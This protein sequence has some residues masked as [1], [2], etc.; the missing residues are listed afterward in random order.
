M[1]AIVIV[2][3]GHAG[4]ELANA[5]RQ[6]GFAGR[7]ILVSDDPA[8]P[9]HRPPLSKDF[10]KGDGLSPLLLKAESFYPQNE[11]ELQLG[12][13]AVAIDRSAQRV[14]LDDG[15]ILAYD[16]LV[17]A[18]GARNRPLPIVGADHDEV[19]TL[20]DLA[21][22]RRILSRLPGLRH[23]AIVGGGFI[24]L[25][26]AAHLREKHIGVDLVE[27]TDRL[28]SRAVSSVMSD[29]FRRFH[30]ELGVTLH[31]QRQAQAI[32]HDSGRATL[33][34]TD[35][36][37]IAADAVLLAAGIVPNTELAADAGLAVGNGI[38]VDAHLLTS[39]PAIS[40]LGDCA[41]FPSRFAGG[42]TRLESVQNA[43]D[44]ARCIAKRLTGQP[45]AY[46]AV[47]WFWSNQG[48]ARLQIA[49]IGA[50]HDETIIRGDADAGAFSTFLYRGD[51]LLAVESVNK[52][53]DH[54]LAR[55]LIESGVTLPKHATADITTELGI[56]TGTPRPRGSV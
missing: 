49:G 28:M 56:F 38:V 19:M 54:M 41:A 11:V 24:G 32:A 34:L 16:H 29:Y 26:I 27:M 53:R 51:R 42:N 46:C 8:L 3:A 23:V 14:R 40:A 43:V 48:T 47:P 55:K 44:Q 6:Q 50:G 37:R 30:E 36:R 13:R 31:F 45:D 22:A 52:A 20:R 12:R 15:Q 4:V 21:D 35:G 10:L 17:L 2:G 33:H 25:E 5:L 9:Y 39:D 1:N 7:V 18:T